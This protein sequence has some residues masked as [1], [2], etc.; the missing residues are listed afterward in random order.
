MCKCT[1]KSIPCGRHLNARRARLETVR[2]LLLFLVCL[3]PCSAV[4]GTAHLLI[5]L[6]LI[7]VELVNHLQKYA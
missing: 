1:S 2:L 7:E 3:C 5:Q 6:G 4:A